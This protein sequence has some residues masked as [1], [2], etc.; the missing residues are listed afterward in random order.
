MADFLTNLWESVFTPGPT[1]TLVYATN[2]SFFALQTVLL[3]LLAA[4]YSI[5]FL[6]LSFLCGGLW[7]AINWFVR[8]LEI[9]KRLEKEKGTKDREKEGKQTGSEGDDEDGGDDDDGG[10][11][12]TEDA[13]PDVKRDAEDTPAPTEPEA[14][15]LHPE[16]A[17]I[18]SQLRR[19]NRES[20]G[21]GSS[22][23]D[24]STDSEW[25]KVEEAQEIGR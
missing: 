22:A 3:L 17:A 20:L 8:E 25:D 12:E 24:L 21:G 23:G 10:G 11:T 1:P 6:I 4:T 7:W 2:A 19:R 5:H 13:G 14:K 15:Q 18:E 16:D 9:A